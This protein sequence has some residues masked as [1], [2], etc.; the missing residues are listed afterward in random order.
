MDEEK[1]I[2]GKKNLLFSVLS[3]LLLCFLLFP[4]YWALITSLKNEHLENTMSSP[5]KSR[6]VIM[7]DPLT[8]KI[9]TSGIL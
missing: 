8:I 7:I 6:E 4:L 9:S 3:V 5:I 1:K 2:T